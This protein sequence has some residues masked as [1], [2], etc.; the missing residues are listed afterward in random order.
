MPLVVSALDIARSKTMAFFPLNGE[1]ATSAVP[2]VA[3]QVSCALC[4][5]ALTAF[6][7]ALSVLV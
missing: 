2:P 5:I 1:V 6:S 4:T 3:S 7:P